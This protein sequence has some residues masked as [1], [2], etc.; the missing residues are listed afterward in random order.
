MS[1][2]GCKVAVPYSFDT[3]PW[4][5]I[6]AV[7]TDR[8]AF[9]ITNPSMAMYDAVGRRCAEGQ[10]VL[11][12]MPESS[13]QSVQIWRFDPYQLCPIGTDGVRSCPQD[14]S[15]TY[16]LLPGFIYVQ[17]ETVCNQTFNVAAPTI[18]YLDENNLVITVLQT[19]FVNVD[20]LTLRP[21]NASLARCVVVVWCR[22]C[23]YCQFSS[24][25]SVFV[26]AAAITTTT[27]DQILFSGRGPQ[28][29]HHHHR[30]MHH[31][32]QFVCA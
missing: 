4:L 28:F 24:S 30:M 11:A 12:L 19:T 8:F 23:Y 9:W 13:Y 22:C 2:T 10:G 27:T 15:A 17:D 26:V 18:S 31:P 25:S 20:C 1:G 32:S 3:T 29:P 6:P 5:N 21:I 14:T 7:V 16:K